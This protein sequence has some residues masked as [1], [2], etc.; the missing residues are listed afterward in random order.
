MF[1]HGRKKLKLN[2]P[3]PPSPHIHVPSNSHLPPV[4]ALD[5]KAMP[6]TRCGCPTLRAVVHTTELD[7][8]CFLNVLINVKMK[9]SP[10]QVTQPIHKVRWSW[11]ISKQQKKVIC[12]KGAKPSINVQSS[13]DRA[14]CKPHFRECTNWLKI[15]INRLY[16]LLSC[17]IYISAAFSTPPGALWYP[18]DQS[19]V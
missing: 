17:T 13:N 19:R 1:G 8:C 18:V 10:S 14:I 3:S 12:E 2:S 16:Y 7:L 6:N 4:G 11:I 9:D 5:G 15:F